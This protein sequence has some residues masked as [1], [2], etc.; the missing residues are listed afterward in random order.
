MTCKLGVMSDSSQMRKKLIFDVIPLATHV[1][2]IIGL[3]L[4][5]IL[6]VTRKILDTIQPVACTINYDSSFIELAA[7]LNYDRSFIVLA[8]V[9]TIVNYDCKT[10]IV[11]ATDVMSLVRR[12]KL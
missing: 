3:T 12:E 2:L 5:F 11:Q 10:F 8:T 1:K 7:S 6:L 9:I 4:S